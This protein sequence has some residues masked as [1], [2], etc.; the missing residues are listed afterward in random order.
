MTA[1]RYLT[2]GESHGR[3]L[4]AVVEGVPSGLRVTP[5]VVDRELARRQVGYGRG[6]RMQIETDRAQILSGVRRG[7]SMGGPITLMI[8]NTDATLDQLPVVTR[9]RPGHA[10]LTGGLKYAHRD[11]R[12]VLER[13]SARETAARVAV[14]ALA[15]ALLAE[16]GVVI[17]SH[18]VRIGPV[19]ARPPRL[20]YAAVRRRAEAS[21]VRCADPRAARM[22]VRVIDEMKR[23]GDTLGGVF[24]VVG[25]GLPVGLGSYVHA[26]RKLDGRLAQAV[27]S[28]Q[29]VKGVEVGDGVEGSRRPGSAFHDEVYYARG[30][31]FYRR[32]NAAGG[33][34]G[35]MTNGQPLMVRGYQK[36][37]STLRKPLRSVNILSK[38]PE[39]AQVERSD[40]C[41]VPAAG[42]IAEA[43]V[44]FVLAQAWLEKF[45]GDS[46]REVARN[47]R[48]YL[49]Q[50]KRW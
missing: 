11:M 8:D 3:C 42:V 27:L 32:T 39:V 7:R 31:G 37:L 26:D 19:E 14:G 35:G 20:S 15:K 12:N 21:L 44:A 13:A 29:S 10:D 33:I 9:P 2:A 47:V 23:A 5:D 16:F 24:E 17:F 25:L 49:A 41:T 46:L 6:P 50:V 43:V 48:G 30:R 18:V 38:R 4:V 34:E 45:G 36:P 40:V 1:L 22:M 28:I